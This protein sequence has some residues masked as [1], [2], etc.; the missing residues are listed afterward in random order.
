VVIVPAK[1]TFH[2]TWSLT[3]KKQHRLSVL[4]KRVMG[5][6]PGPEKQDVTGRWRKLHNDE[7]HDFYSFP[8]ITEVK[9]NED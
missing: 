2:E 7:L 5:K 9:M 4:Q 6:I 3:L 1:V 8:N